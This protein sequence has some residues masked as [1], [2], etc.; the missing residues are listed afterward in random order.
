MSARTPSPRTR[1]TADVSRPATPKRSA[2][3]GRVGRTPWPHN[4][5]WVAIESDERGGL[6]DDGARRVHQRVELRRRGTG[7]ERRE[8]A[9]EVVRR[10]ALGVGPVTRGDDEVAVLHPGV[11]PHAVAAAADRRV[12]RLDDGVALLAREWPAAKSTIVPRPRGHE[13][14][15][16]R[17]LVGREVDAHRRGFDG[18]PAGVELEGS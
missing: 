7:G 4:Q 13:V 1:S 5:I 17:D 2:K 6:G 14:A 11:E 16:V 15:P 8:P 10:G 12:E 3:G 18:G 9:G